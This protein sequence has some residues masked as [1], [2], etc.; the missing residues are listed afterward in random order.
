MQETDHPGLLG[1]VVIPVRGHDPKKRSVEEKIRKGPGSDHA[2]Q[3]AK[4]PCVAIPGTG[5]TAM[6][7]DPARME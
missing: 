5:L 3:P 1:N 7:A 2:H 6:L 4:R